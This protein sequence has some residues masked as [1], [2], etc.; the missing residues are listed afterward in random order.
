M[1]V[2]LEFDNHKA[3]DNF[4]SWWLDGGGEQ[5]LNFNTTDFDLKDGY[6]KIEG[7]GIQG[8]EEF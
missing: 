6:L 2:T 7:S 5:Y 1:I 8:D 4:M 3:A